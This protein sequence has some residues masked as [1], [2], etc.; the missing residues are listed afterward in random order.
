MMIRSDPPGALVYVDD[1]PIGTTPVATNFTYYGTRQIRLVKSGFE[2]LTVMQPIRPPWHQIMPLDFITENFIPGEIRDQRTLNYRLAPQMMIPTEQLRER[3]ED[4]RAA[5][6]PGGVVRPSS[7]APQSV[8]TPPA[9]D[10]VHPLP[11]GPEIISAPAGV[12]TTS[13]RAPSGGPSFQTL[14]PGGVPLEN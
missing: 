9:P 1:Y 11:A 7:F 10:R 2:T 13:T 14:P 6:R 3:A 12:P 8:I 5:S 4:L